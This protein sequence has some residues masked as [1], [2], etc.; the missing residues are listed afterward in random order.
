MT[1]SSFSL[2]ELEFVT[3]PLC[4]PETHTKLRVQFGVFR[5]MTCTGCGLDFLSPRLTERAI[6]NLYSNESYYK[7]EVIGLGYDEY[8]E[9]RPNW[10]K[11][12]KRRLNEI[13][14]YQAPGKL[15]DVGCG[16][17]FFLEVAQSRGYEVYGIDPSEYIVQQARLR[18]G[19][20][21]R[22]GTLETIDYPTEEFDLV[23]AFDTF[24]HIYQPVEWL[25]IVHRILRPN[26][27]LA[28]TTP[29]S[30]SLLARLSGRR[31]V[32]YKIPEHVFYWSPA[33]MRRALGNDWQ[34][35]TISHAGQYATLGFLFRRLFHLRPQSEGVLGWLIQRLNK[36]SVYADNGSM[37]VIARKI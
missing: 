35:L 29:D 20:R 4:S 13:M 8:I 18:F 21:I 19:N 22:K 26:G 25:R 11:T 37:T 28:I 5:V 31:W 17:G 12:F 33:P 34:I 30:T 32:S 10:L 24:E 27:L 1:S 36:F 16:P 9:A 14:R 7:S 15:L 2:S 6:L 3:C 23:T